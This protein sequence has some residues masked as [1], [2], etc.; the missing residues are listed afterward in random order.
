MP[1]SNYDIVKVEKL[2]K[3]S[4]DT[5][6]LGLSLCI[7]D[8]KNQMCYTDY[9]SEKKSDSTKYIVD[10]PNYDKDGNDVSGHHP[11]GGGRRRKDGTLETSTD[12]YVRLDDYKDTIREEIKD[13]LR[14]EIKEQVRDEVR[15]ELESEQDYSYY[16]YG[17]SSSDNKA[18]TLETINDFF[19]AV[20]DLADFI[21]N[22]PELVEGAIKLGGKVKHGIVDGFGRI[23]NAIQKRDISELVRSSIKTE[24]LRSD[25][26]EE[27]TE[28]EYYG[29]EEHVD[30]NEEYD[31]AEAYIEDDNDTEEIVLT[32]DEAKFFCLRMVKNY[33]ELRRDY[34][35]LRKA[36]VVDA[37][38]LSEMMQQLEDLVE[39]HPKLLEEATQ[40]QI[41]DL[42]ETLPDELERRRILQ[43]FQMNA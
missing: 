25:E 3:A 32:D 34:E 8:Y 23:K 22:N 41:R 4:N 17:E 37:E 7:E 14:E 38:K 30:Q 15:N 40:K 28:D 29:I 18:D 43:L 2:I 24:T 20:G 12:N 21:D 5:H 9:M 31:L 26:N 42:L 19:D 11:R 36:R 1:V 6:P 10:V 33:I 13:E 27:V 16:N 35:T 39:S